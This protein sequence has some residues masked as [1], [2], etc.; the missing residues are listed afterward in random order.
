MNLLPP[1]GW[2]PNPDNPNQQ[3]YWDGGQWTEHL[4]VPVPVAT[5]AFPAVAEPTP[6][7]TI[8]LSVNPVEQN[9]PYDT[10]YPTQQYPAQYPTQQYPTQQYPAQPYMAGTGVAS[11]KKSKLPVILPIVILGVVAIGV[12]AFFGIRAFLANGLVPPPINPTAE[13]TPTVEPTTEPTPDPTP[14]IPNYELAEI[15]DGPTDVHVLNRGNDYETLIYSADSFWGDI[16]SGWETTA[17][18][19]LWKNLK[20]TTNTCEAIHIRGRISESDITFTNPDDDVSATHEFGWLMLPEAGPIEDYAEFGIWYTGIGQNNPS[21]IPT[22]LLALDYYDET[23]DNLAVVYV[24][25][26]TQADF[27]HFTALRCTDP[28]DYDIAYYSFID[29]EFSIEAK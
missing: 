26:F 27:A 2:Y 13:P 1:A 6:D 9:A 7:V 23:V 21:A 10:Q 20:S 15:V 16:G 24:R 29:F 28:E 12:A 4:H 18:D 8:P 11:T 19:G 25:V 5:P 17:D 14:T 22:D 3:R